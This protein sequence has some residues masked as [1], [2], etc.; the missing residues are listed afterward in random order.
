MKS[1]R[2]TIASLALALATLPAAVHAD[3]HSPGPPRVEAEAGKKEPSPAAPKNVESAEDAAKVAHHSPSPAT[4]SKSS[5]KKNS[6][7]NPKKAKPPTQ[8]VSAPIKSAQP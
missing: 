2:C 8:A 4:R 5:N 7:A 3:H 6:A 1:K